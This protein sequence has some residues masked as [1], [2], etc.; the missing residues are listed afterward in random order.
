MREVADVYRRQWLVCLGR[1]RTSESQG[2]MDKV[3][4]AYRTALAICSPATMSQ[5]Y[6]LPGG[7]KT[8]V[9]VNYGQAP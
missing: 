4:T 1:K 8:N 9:G 3:L 6:P 5:A 7:E 2:A